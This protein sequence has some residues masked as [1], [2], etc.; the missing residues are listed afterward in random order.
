[1]IYGQTGSTPTHTPPFFP[2][3]HSINGRVS[4]L[5]EWNLLTV[6][7]ISRRQAERHRKKNC[8]RQKIDGDWRNIIGEEQI[9][10]RLCGRRASVSEGCGTMLAVEL[11]SSSPFLPF[12]ETE[13]WQLKLAVKLQE[14]IVLCIKQNKGYISSFK[15][16]CFFG[17]FWEDFICLKKTENCSV[18]LKLKGKKKVFNKGSAV[19]TTT[20]LFFFFFQTGKKA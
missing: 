20:S 1:M 6:A 8:T 15:I 10:R 18:F 16:K 19:M 2:V 9:C 13:F 4:T 3:S 7:A 14:C 12:Q 5:S 11:F 17:S